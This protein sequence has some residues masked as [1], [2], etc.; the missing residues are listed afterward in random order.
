MTQNFRGFSWQA[1]R[2]AG[3][4]FALTISSLLAFLIYAM[5]IVRPLFLPESFP[6]GRLDG[7][8][9]YQNKP[10]H[11]V[12]LLA[13]ILAVGLLYLWGWWAVRRLKGKKAQTSAWVI[14]LAG[15]LGCAAALLFLHPFD[16]ADIFD[17]IMHGRI[18]A[19]YGDNPFIQAG[20]HYPEDPFFRYMAWKN[21]PSGYGP[22][23]EIMAGF[24]ARMAGDSVVANVLAFKLLPG[25]FWF[26]S[27][28]LVGFFLSKYVPG[29]ALSGV[30]L[31]AWNPM[32]LYSTFG[33]GH[34]DIVMVFWVLLAIWAIQV[35]RDTIAV[36]ALLAG[37][38]V[39]YIPLLLLPAAL[40][41]ALSRIRTTRYGG[42][43][44]TYAFAAVKYLGV[45]AVLGLG[46]IW[47]TFSPFWAG[48]ETLTVER[49]TRLYTSS[50]PAVAYHALAPEWGEDSASQF[51][52]RV[53]A[54]ATAAFV[55]WRTWRLGKET[56]DQQIQFDRRFARASFDILV[57]YL[58]VT[59]LWFQQWYTIWL[60]G[61]AA[62]MT[63][64]RRQRLGAFF[65]LAAFSKQLIAA[66]MLF[67]PRPTF[68]QPELELRF[69]LGVLGLPWLYLLGAYYGSVRGVALKSGLET[70]EFT[71]TRPGE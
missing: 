56:P 39:K 6:R 8:Y 21:N 64:G 49:R 63:Y 31:L 68:P 46:L 10:Y 69:T 43:M 51:V 1:L 70:V 26:A 27:V 13:S 50:I 19:V 48:L 44:Q 35:Q 17:N 41:I 52:S 23:W 5:G 30:Y 67:R 45:T 3:P 71:E 9:I 22:L 55:L 40:W 29:Q 15:A 66:P 58:L 53:A 33:N 12:R 14:V 2:P 62:I 59:C 38:L 61:L 34:N 57:F 42:G 7:I 11:Q 25:I 54:I 36:L 65:S 28:L 24:A 18:L 47:L 60:V 37:A 20:K 4:L 32:V 16:A